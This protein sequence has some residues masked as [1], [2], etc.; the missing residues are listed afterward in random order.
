MANR[1]IL[2]TGEALAVGGPPDALKWHQGSHHPARSRG[3]IYD[4][5]YGTRAG[6]GS[7]LM[8]ASVEKLA[9]ENM[10]ARAVY[11]ASLAA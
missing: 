5:K 6:I 11:A 2:R 4:F 9:V 10:L 3:P 8:K 7:A 1:I